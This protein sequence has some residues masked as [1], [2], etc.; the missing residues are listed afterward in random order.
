MPPDVRAK[1]TSE[2]ADGIKLTS[3]VPHP[4]VRDNEV[5]G[6]QNLT[7][8]IDTTQLNEVFFEIN[9]QPYDPNR[10]DRTLVLGGVDEWS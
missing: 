10:I 7:F 1:I 6:T 9:G 3:F 2:I 5:T 4:D 8:N